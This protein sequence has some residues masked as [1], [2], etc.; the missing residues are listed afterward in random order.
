VSPAALIS[1]ISGSDIIPS[2]RTGTAF[3]ISGSF[4]TLIETTSS[5]PIT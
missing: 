4:H 5:A 1:P 2:G 3:D